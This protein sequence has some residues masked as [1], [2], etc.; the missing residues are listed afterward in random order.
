MSST[1]TPHQLAQPPNSSLPFFTKLIYG[2]GD[3]SMASFNTIRQIYYAI[4]LTD[5]VG[6]PPGLASFAALIGIIWDAINDPLIGALSDKTTSRW[7]RRRPF[8]LIFAIPFAAAFVL[9]WWAPPW[10][11]V[12]LKA[13]HVTLA[14]IIADTLQTFVVIPFLSLTPELTEDYDERTSLTT[15]RMFFN[16]LA[17]LAAAA[18]APEVIARAPTTQSGYL[19]MA[20]LFGASGAIP[21]LAIFFF[22]R[23]RTNTEPAPAIPLLTGLRSAFSNVPFRIAIILNVLNWLTFDLVALMLPYFLTYWVNQGEQIR[24]VEVP[25]IG[26]LSTTS[27]IFL[28]LLSTAIAALPLWAY[29]ARHWNK[30]PAYITGMSFWLVIQ[31]LI[32]TIR[33]NQLNY[34]LV[35]ACFAGI[36]VSTAHVLPNALFPDVLEWDELRTGQRRDGLYYGILNLTR[37]ATSAIAIFLALQTLGIFNYQTPPANAAIFPQPPGAILAIRYLTGPAGALLLFG[38]IIAASFYPITRERHARMRTLLAR[39]RARRRTLATQAH[40]SQQ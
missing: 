21:F 2:T 3:W 15:Y 27:L 24:N 25:V 10:D 35:L 26:T 23:E 39:K 16:L 6:I 22:T 38:A 13:L 4:F 14:Y 9:L 11:N 28:I 40:S 34:L 17:S 20:T 36:S 1:Q 37:K 18:V 30:R 29:V 7:G 12:Y 19:I 31:C 32:L 33:P 5:V 8:L